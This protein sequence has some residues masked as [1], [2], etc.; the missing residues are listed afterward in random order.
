MMAAINIF[1]EWFDADAPHEVDEALFLAVA[2]LEIK[3]DQVL[4][5]VR[6]FRL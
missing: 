6:H 2:P 1:L 3:L 4:D 5:H